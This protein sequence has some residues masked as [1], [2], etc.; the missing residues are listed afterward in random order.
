ML[1]SPLYLVVSVC[2]LLV[3]GIPNFIAW[4]ILSFVGS[5]FAKYPH[6][7]RDIFAFFVGV[8]RFLIG[9]A[10][11]SWLIKHLQNPSLFFLESMTVKTLTIDLVHVGLFIVLV[12][13]D[14]YCP[15]KPNNEID[16]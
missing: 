4:C 13:L 16:D 3:G 9:I 11:V 8:T 12:L 6:L 7:S 15:S 10:L 14:K 1:E 2:I 5:F